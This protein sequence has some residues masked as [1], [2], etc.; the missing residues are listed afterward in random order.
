MPNQ[1]IVIDVTC[2]NNNRS[3]I[4]AVSIPHGMTQQ[5]NFTIASGS[6]TVTVQFGDNGTPFQ[7]AQSS[8]SVGS[9]GSLHTTNS[10]AA[11][12]DYGFSASSSNGGPRT[13]DI[14]IVDPPV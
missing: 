10:S 4:G 5:V 1:A 6:P 8:F 2:D 13:G 14:D 9:S 3:R 7:D 12:N 11:V